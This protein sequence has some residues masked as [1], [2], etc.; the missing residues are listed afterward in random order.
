MPTIF[1]VQPLVKQ[2]YSQNCVGCCLHIVLDDGNVSDLN[3]KFC[4]NEAVK[5][6]HYFCEELART[7]LLMTLTQ[8]KRLYMS[9]S[10]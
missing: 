8:R 6:K 1:E 3:V 2:L 9:R 10:W 4:I 5:N 7:I